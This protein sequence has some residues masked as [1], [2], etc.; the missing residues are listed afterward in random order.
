MTRAFSNLFLESMAVTGSGS[1]VKEVTAEI[2][3][4]QVDGLPGAPLTPTD[5]VIT[6]DGDTF[7]D[8][9]EGYD[10]SGWFADFPDGLTAEVKE[11]VSE[12]DDSIIITLS[13]KPDDP[14]DPSEAE[15]DIT[16]PKGFLSDG[17]DDIEIPPTSDAVY[18]IDDFI[19]SIADFEAFARVVNDGAYG[20]S[21]TMED[22]I[23]VPD[24]A[25]YIPIARPV[26]VDNEL[27]Y[28]PYEGTFN[29]QGHTIT[30]ALTGTA[31]YLALFGANN[32]MIQNLTV[33]G[34]VTATIDR[35]TPKDIDYVAGVVAYNDI[36]GTIEQVISQVN[37]T[38]DDSFVTSDHKDIAI[39]SIGG[40]A[41][42]NGWDQYSPDSP[43]YT[44]SDED[45]YEAGGDI[46]QCRN[47]GTII[48]GQ[49]KIGGIAGENAGDIAQCSNRGTIEC[50]KS[51]ELHP[52]WPG[53]GGIA[54]RNGNNNIPTEKGRILSCY[55]W[56][57]IIDHT[58]KT[59]DHN[60]YGGITGWCDDIDNA[61]VKDCYTTGEFC[62]PDSDYQNHP[63]S[64]TKNPIIGSVDEDKDGMTSNNY[65]LDSIH[66][67]TNEED[68]ALTGTPKTIEEMK[69]PTFVTA[70]NGGPSGPFV[71]NTTV[72]PYCPKLSWE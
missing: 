26:M 14:T 31:S 46:H 53:V 49:N 67:S 16:I 33:G 62:E 13:G 54:G 27:V 21:V 42:F 28:H 8:I 2:E 37:I 68:P 32:G 65:A 10:V 12:G 15:I 64:G 44:S 1:S 6:L 23:E 45:T 59:I 63:V 11:A 4:V 39:H 51:G 17:E 22:D 7:I 70:L 41:G 56:G 36:D 20:R 66:R 69:D 34:S 25:E 57:T 60:D 55:N 9:I 38:A 58:N 61:I 40:I 19:R 30:I 48:G 35:A 24:T 43:H 29:G 50:F 72:F 71:L 3:P 52:R 5:V 47:E 18:R